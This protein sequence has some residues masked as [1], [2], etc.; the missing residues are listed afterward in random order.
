MVRAAVTLLLILMVFPLFVLVTDSFMGSR[1][2]LER[3]GPVLAGTEGQAEFVLFPHFL[4]R[5][6]IRC[7]RQE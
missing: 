7:F 4:R 3:F 5:S 1:E 6:G 2:I